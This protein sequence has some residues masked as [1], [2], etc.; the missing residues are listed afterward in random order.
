VCLRTT[1]LVCAQQQHRSARPALRPCGSFS[2]AGESRAA[3]GTSDYLAFGAVRARAPGKAAGPKCGPCA[4]F[5]RRALAG[6]AGS[7][8]ATSTS[9]V[10]VLGN[11]I[12]TSGASRGPGRNQILLRLS[13]IARVT[14]EAR[15]ERYEVP[16]IRCQGQKERVKGEG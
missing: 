7:N 14:E 16:G 5:F 1:L 8:A 11:V 3:V 13:G 15:K 6:R 2:V 4:T 10:S 12:A 9:E